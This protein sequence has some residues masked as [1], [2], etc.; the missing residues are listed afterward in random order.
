MIYFDYAESLSNPE[1]K[2][3]YAIKINYEIDTNA[4]GDNTPRRVTCATI[5]RVHGMENGKPVMSSVA[6]GESICHPKDN[7]VKK[8]GRM[9]AIK[10]AISYAYQAAAFQSS[11]I[12]RD[13][14]FAHAVL[15]VAN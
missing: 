12:R 7:F 4:F 5:Y 9:K 2:T 3:K 15:S 8:L 10:N 13:S 1:I 14:D 6:Y 11:Y